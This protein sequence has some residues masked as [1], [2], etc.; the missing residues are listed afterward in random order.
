MPFIQKKYRKLA[1]L[2]VSGNC[3]EAEKKSFEQWLAVS[4]EHQDYFAS[5]QQAWKLT[6]AA[7]L[8]TEIDTEK[9]LR[10]VNSKIENITV[11]QRISK[12]AK[13]SVHRLVVRIA[14]SA[15]AVLLLGFVMYYFTRSG[16]NTEPV[17]YTAQNNQQAAFQLADGS[18][19]F[20]QDGSVLQFHSNFEQQEER[21]VS[22]EGEGLFEVSHDA[23]KPFVVN[24]GNLQI[25][26]LGTTFNLS[27]AAG[28]SV[29]TCDLIEGKVRFA[30]IDRSNG[31]VLEQLVLLPGQRGTYNTASNQ[32]SRGESPANA[33]SW[34]T[35]VLA[36]NNVPL[37]EVMKAIAQ[38]Y[39]LTI[40]LD[41]GLADLK[42]TARFEQEK[43]ESILEAI[44]VIFDLEIT[45]TEN[46][47]IIR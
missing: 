14:S 16:L 6:A 36:F 42:L 35:G 12:L 3:T 30:L 41:P 33:T 23:A 37:A 20:M 22:F 26:V 17:A 28:A 47:V 13:P 15:A 40:D 27:A 32:I 43:P 4:R 19:V 24:A 5:F 31:Q 8:Q 18:Q 2:Y 46:R 11:N 9:A 44:R 21:T 25:E 7:S 29:Y 39:K 45:Q 38:T 1:T 10:K 34:K